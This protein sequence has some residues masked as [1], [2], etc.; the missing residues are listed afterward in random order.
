MRLPTDDDVPREAE[1]ADVRPLAVGPVRDEDVP[2]L[3]VAMDEP[4][5]VRRVERLARLAHQRDGAPGLEPSLASQE[6]A[7]IDAVD[8]LHREVE[9]AAVL[10]RGDR[11]HDVRVVERRRQARL[12]QEA[13]P[14]PLVVGELGREQLQRDPPPVRVL[15]EV[16]GPHRPARKQLPDAEPADDASGRTVSAHGSA[17]P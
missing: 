16:D 2:G 9:H 3:H 4:G 7:Q 13:L 10:A 8:V 1:V 14:E 12:A 17:Q 6:L 5:R 11:P 15:R